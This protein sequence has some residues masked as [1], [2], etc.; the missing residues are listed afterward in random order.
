METKIKRIFFYTVMFV[1]STTVLFDSGV[2]LINSSLS[3]IQL[4]KHN[5]AYAEMSLI[6]CRVF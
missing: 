6:N 5:L 3:L 2:R 1:N 4:T